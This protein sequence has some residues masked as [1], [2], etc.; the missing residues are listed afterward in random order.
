M[1]IHQQS[2]QPVSG[3]GVRQRDGNRI[4]H[5]IQRLNGH[6]W[7]I[8]V[9]HKEIPDVESIRLPRHNILTFS[10]SEA[11]SSRVAAEAVATG[12]PASFPNSLTCP[13]AGYRFAPSQHMRLFRSNNKASHGA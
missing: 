10:A 3:N 2:V 9:F 1:P 11:Y 13:G 7:V 8:P 6:S 4:P 5:A 12:E